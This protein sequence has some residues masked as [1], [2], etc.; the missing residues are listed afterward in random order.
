VL[1]Q[2]GTPVYVGCVEALLRYRPKPGVTVLSPSREPLLLR[3]TPQAPNLRLGQVTKVT[4]VDTEGL[5]SWTSGDLW[6]VSL[7]LSLTE[8]LNCSSPLAWCRLWLIVSSTSP[9]SR[10]GQ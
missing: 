2:L 8:L 10:P 6:V 7:L 3:H 4:E 1:T 5:C 9:R